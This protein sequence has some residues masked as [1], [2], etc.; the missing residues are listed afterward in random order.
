M[1]SGGFL[2]AAFA[3]FPASR[4]GREEVEVLVDGIVDRGMGYVP[5]QVCRRSSSPVVV[6]SYFRVSSG[7]D[8]ICV[9]D[10]DKEKFR[11]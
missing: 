5:Y 2:C 11:R 7:V 10:A 9:E 8:I 1:L 4:R 3:L 6:V